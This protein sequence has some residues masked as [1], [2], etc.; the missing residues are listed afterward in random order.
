MANTNLSYS[1]LIENSGDVP[2]TFSS[3]DAK[4]TTGSGRAKQGDL[5]AEVNGKYTK[6]RQDRRPLESTWFYNAAL[7]RGLNQTKWNPVMNMLEHRKTPAHRDR[8]NINLI[9]PKVKAKL[10]KFLQNRAIP[11]V[12]AATTDHED[13]LNAKATTKVLEYLWEKLSLEQMYEEALLWSMQ[14]GKAFWWLS[15]NQKGIAQIREDEADIFGKQQVHDVEAGEVHVELGTAFEIL[16]ADPGVMHLRHQPEIMRVKIRPIKDV[17]KEFKL[18]PGS[19]EGDTQE[20]QLFQ[21][22]KQIASLGTRATVGT[23]SSVEQKA[24]GEEKN[25][26]VV[27]KELFTAPCAA[28]AQGRY[29]AIA[30][31]THLNKPQPEEPEIDPLTGL[32]GE[33]E[34]P[35]PYAPLPYDLAQTGSPYP[36]VE[37]ADTVTA[38]QFWPTTM[39]EQLAGPQKVYLRLRRQIDEHTK[40]MTHP[41]IFIPKQAQIH[42]Q[43]WGSEAGQKIYYNYQPGLPPPNQWV[44]SPNAI[45]NDV[46]RLLDIVKNEMDT[47]SNLY[48]ASL[49]QKGATS[50]FETNLLQEAADSV[51]APDIRRN[52][53]AL[54][55]AAYK[56]RRLA[57]M[58]YDV[59]RLIAITGRDKSPDVFEFSSEQIDEHA[60]III[61]TG[62]ALPTQKH[63]KI[64]A[65]LKLDER[66][67]FG[68]PGDP[69]RNRK[70]V[71][72]LDLGSYQEDADLVAADEDHA[73]LEN[74][75]FT[76]GEPVE[77]PMPWENHDIEYDIHTGLLKSPEIKSWSPEQRAALVRHVILHVKWKNPQNALQ[78][79]AVFGMQDVV[80]EIQQTMMI[81][82]SVLAPQGAAPAGP[83]PPQG[84]EPQA[85]QPPAPPAQAP[86]AA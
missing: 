34:P 78:L 81:Q 80:M 82:Q 48:P 12:Q 24:S 73:R 27:V 64:E 79:A 32:P 23:T 22:Q 38:G 72:A 37:F 67:V 74:L 50:G 13:I 83:P 18:P 63:A 59:P 16:V 52:E 3:S 56:M 75:S 5:V 55:D 40:L 19:I 58:G 85:Q 36:C 70:I 47:L 2:D 86:P 17:E 44:V 39:V 77:D 65:I 30:G 53:L 62:S 6:W 14:T 25:T 26:H 7:V 68:P 20:S 31:S 4:D 66:Q 51:H 41:W 33:V 11:V 71:R 60:N 45:S 1:S 43:A 42:Q 76:R 54:K 9:L 61:D 28:Y 15:W 69:T 29:V 46:Y 10:S 84:Q 35:A 21:Y 8:E 49:G 57:K